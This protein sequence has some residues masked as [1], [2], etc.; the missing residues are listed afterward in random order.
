METIEYVGSALGMVGAC[1]NALGS[2]WGRFTWPI[3]LASNVMLLGYTGVRHEWG[4]CAMQA[5][6]TFTTLTGLAREYFPS[7]YA[8]VARALRRFRDLMRR[9]AAT[10]A[11]EAE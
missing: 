11:Q 10:R 9:L 2:G 8:A 1:T 5:F 4:L 6:Y 7:R 3:W